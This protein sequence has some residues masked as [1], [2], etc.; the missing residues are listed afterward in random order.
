MSESGGRRI[1]RSINLD[2]SSV[3]FLK[4]SE[5]AELESIDL[6]KV[7]SENVLKLERGMQVE[8]HGLAAPLL[9]GRNPTN[10]GT[11][12]VLHRVPSGSPCD[13]STRQHFLFGNWLRRRKGC[14]LRFMF[15]SMM[16]AGS[17]TRIIRY[18]RSF[19]GFSA[20]FWFA[21]LSVAK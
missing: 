6:R 14:R 12:G 7:P 21:C 17:I 9:N 2:L 16:Y 5:I 3:C 20:S 1:K 18:F 11:S 8:E 10:S 13:S 19:I 15:L 4:E